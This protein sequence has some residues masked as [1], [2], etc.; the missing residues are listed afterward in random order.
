MLDRATLQNA[1]VTAKASSYVG[2]ARQA[3]QPCRSGAH[4]VAWSD[5]PWSYLDSYFGGTDFSGQEVLWHEG[6][7]VW[8]MSYF[9]YIIHDHLIDAER[10][11]TVI[12]SALGTLYREERRFL[13]GF[14]HAHAFGTYIDESGGD[15]TRFSGRETIRV[16]NV[17]AYSLLYHGGQIRP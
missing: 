6:E 7:P 13:G 16:G 2:G 17:E 4:D 12:K 1:I 3:S 8:A 11:G 14:R 5:G 9:G 10:A 15:C